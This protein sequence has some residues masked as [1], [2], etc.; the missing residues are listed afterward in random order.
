MAGR[1]LT[2]E[3]ARQIWRRAA[4]LQAR[5]ADIASRGALPVPAERVEGLTPG[6]VTAAAVEAGIGSEYV[7]LALA[8]LDTDALAGGRDSRVQRLGRRL[9]GR[10]FDGIDASRT[11]AASPAEVHATMLR[12]FTAPPFGLV[13]TDTRGSNPF[14]DDVLTFDSEA[15]ALSQTPFQSKLNM[16]DVKRLYVTLRP[17]GDG[18]RV[19]IRAPFDRRRLTLFLGGLFTLVPA[20]AG[21][22]IG[23]AIG[24]AIGVAGAATL[25]VPIGVGLGAAAAGARGFRAIY[26]WSVRQAGRA[27]DQ[28]LGALAADVQLRSQGASAG[29]L[30]REDGDDGTRRQ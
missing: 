16:G 25:A 11:I 30:P 1:R 24:A 20:T 17:A 23:T 10:P 3:E 13:L 21:T 28:L 18:C 5:A 9:V 19:A 29:A 22:A 27:L 12:L 14:I 4:E 8:E 15:A 2:E 6:D 26:R 7:Q